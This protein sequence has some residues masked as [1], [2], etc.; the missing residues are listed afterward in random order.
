MT[1]FIS[2][3]ESSQTSFSH[4]KWSNLIAQVTDE[5]FLQSWAIVIIKY[6]EYNEKTQEMPFFIITH[7][8]PKI[9]CNF[10]KNE[11][12][13]FN[14]FWA[15]PHNIYFTK[16]CENQCFVIKKFHL[17]L[18]PQLLAIESGRHIN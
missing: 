13:V 12:F 1:L 3:I 8:R 10:H 7:I 16:I 15:Y 17:F 11:D 4:H 2:S 14:F 18:A 6:G 5:L 9:S